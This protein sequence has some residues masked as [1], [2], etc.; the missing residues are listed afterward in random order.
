[1]RGEWGLSPWQ[2]PL[3]WAGPLE[4]R[5]RGKG[6]SLVRDV[7][8]GGHTGAAGKLQVGAVSPEL[9]GRESN[10]TDWGG[11]GARTVI[12]GMKVW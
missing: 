12:K 6:G 7:S 2:Q 9:P 4:A 11:G 5:D 10:K 3:R 1:M 8:G